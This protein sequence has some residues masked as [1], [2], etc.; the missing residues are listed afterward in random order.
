MINYE[1]IIQDKDTTNLEIQVDD[2]EIGLLLYTGGTTG[3]PKGAMLTHANLYNATYLT[4]THGMKLIKKKKIPAKALISTI[5]HEN[6]I[7]NTY[8]HF[9]CKWPNARSHKSWN[10]TFN[11]FPC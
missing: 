4:P 11:D 10:E 5:R 7:L 2:D 9:S 8:T 6:E 1:K 3:L